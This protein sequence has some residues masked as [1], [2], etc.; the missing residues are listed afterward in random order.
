[1][2]PIIGAVGVLLAGLGYAVAADMPVPGPAPIPPPA[3]Y[4]AYYNW[5]GVYLGVNAGGGFGT[6]SWTNAPVTT[7]PGATTILTGPPVS[8]GGFNV[9]GALAGATLGVNYQTGP[10]LVGFE[11]D[12][13]WSGVQGSSSSAACTGLTTGAAVTLLA[14][15]TC[16]TNLTWFGTARAR[17]GYAFDRVLVFGTA[18]AAF[19]GFQ[20]VI[21][22]ATF[23]G[24]VISGPI[25]NL[26]PQLG[27]T[28]GAGVEYAFTE[29]IS[30]KVEY[31]FANLGT[32]AC[33]TP[34]T[35]GCV[36]T[37]FG[38][39]PLSTV[40]LSSLNIVRVGANYRFSW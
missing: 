1:V 26:P 24:A 19:G 4:P 39:A 13:D 8:T 17:L 9:S 6:S 10:Y 35:G 12:I 20:A 38:V 7:P 2:K 5:S 15:G 16:R 22:N 3:Y 18:G 31:L 32:H 36:A 23:N 34:G 27:W 33:A 11:G 14:G 30:A 25:I 21:P 28:V 40:S 37:P 29:A